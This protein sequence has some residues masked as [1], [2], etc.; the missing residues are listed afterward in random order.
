MGFAQDWESVTLS[1]AATQAAARRRGGAAATS[2]ADESFKQK[3]ALLRDIYREEAQY[4]RDQDHA[5]LEEF[6]QDMAVRAKA[7]TA[8]QELTR[9][10]IES[11]TKLT[12]AQLAA[13]AQL[14]KQWQGDMTKLATSYDSR[15]ADWLLSQSA[16]AYVTDPSLR[17]HPDAFRPLIVDA[18]DRAWDVEDPRTLG[19]YDALTRQFSK[20]GIDGDL[21]ALAGAAARQRK[22]REAAMAAAEKFQTLQIP[23]G[24]LTQEAVDEMAMTLGSVSLG[25]PT[26]VKDTTEEE[27]AADTHYQA[28]EARRKALEGEGGG[29]SAGSGD[30]S[31]GGLG[32]EKAGKILAD[33]KFR[34]W[35]KDHGYMDLGESTDAGTYR[36][37]KDSYKALSAATAELSGHGKGDKGVEGVEITT[38]HSAP[39]RFSFSSNPDGSLA[40]YVYRSDGSILRTDFLNPDKDVLVRDASGKVDPDAREEMTREVGLEAK[41]SAV[42]VRGGQPFSLAQIASQVKAGAFNPEALTDKE[43]ELEQL[44]DAQT[45]RGQRLRHRIGDDPDLTM[46][47]MQDNGDVVKLHRKSATAPWEVMDG[48]V[49]APTLEMG[50][51]TV[52]PKSHLLDALDVLT[53]KLPKQEAQAADVE[54]RDARTVGM[55]SSQPLPRK[56]GEAPDTVINPFKGGVPAP[57]GTKGTAPAKAPE[58]PVRVQGPATKPSD[59]EALSL[60]DFSWGGRGSVEASDAD[61]PVGT[62]KVS[63]LGDKEITAEDLGLAPMSDARSRLRTEYLPASAS[64]VRGVQSDNK[65]SAAKL[66]AALSSEADDRAQREDADALAT[67]VQA[68]GKKDELPSDIQATL[69]ETAPG[70]KAGP[71]KAQLLQDAVRKAREFARMRKEAQTETTR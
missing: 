5:R 44:T 8:Q 38:G 68:L 22:Q 53:G 55:P 45:V 36:F 23:P 60:A 52:R 43:A 51:T 48:K 27:L 6:K 7:V 2:V 69:D 42:G 11:G 14:A 58:T 21:P 63:P 24:G 61:A 50:K 29:I 13:N 12:T 56:A 17:E 64:A 25:T 19:L 57:K 66:T 70:E 4:V 3:S 30:S 67:K 71:S 15:G 59:N 32:S 34:A 62:G 18:I 49:Q 33:P 46:R 39:D 9:T 10:L 41:P 28:L 31:Y 47:V 65:Q 37:G 20:A 26:E 1:S 40:A 16:R 54:E 35:A